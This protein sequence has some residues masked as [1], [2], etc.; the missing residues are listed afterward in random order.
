MKN[1]FLTTISLFAF[2]AMSFGQIAGTPHDLSGAL[3]QPVGSVNKVCGSCHTPHNAVSTM[4]PLWSHATTAVGSYV[5]Y[6]SVTMTATTG[7]PDASSK[8]CLSCHDGTVAVNNFVPTNLT[9][10]NISGSSNIG[11]DLSNDHPISFTYDD[12]LAGTDGGLYPPT[13]TLSTLT[14][15][16]HISDDMLFG[17]KMQCA[18]CHDVHDNS[19]GQFQRMVNTNSEL[20]LTCH[21]K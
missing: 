7:Q 15:A 4:V 12:A 2:T 1:L 8:A 17:G 5:L 19:N 10:V 20:C 18:S 13:T 16:G 14:A 11:T 6:G 21:N 9:T 3:W